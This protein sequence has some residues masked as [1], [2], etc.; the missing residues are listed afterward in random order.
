MKRSHHTKRAILRGFR[1]GFMMLVLGGT[2]VMTARA[3]EKSTLGNTLAVVQTADCV[4]ATMNVNRGGHDDLL[5]IVHADHS[6]IRCLA[7]MGGLNLLIR[8][9]QP[10]TIRLFIYA[11]SVGV[12]L[13]IRWLTG[14][15]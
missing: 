1:V 10:Q 13:N 2:G 7:V 9:Q 11:D 5:H 4:T 3:D 14:A 6:V 12:G 8:R 15:K